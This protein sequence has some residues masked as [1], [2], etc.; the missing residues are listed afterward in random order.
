MTSPIELRNTLH[1]IDTC[2]PVPSSTSASGLHHGV[3]DNDGQQ[4]SPTARSLSSVDGPENEG[5]SGVTPTGETQPNLSPNPTRG[6][7][8]NLKDA[9]E[10]TGDDTFF[11]ESIAIEVR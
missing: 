11:V 10:E 3:R 4:K 1:P 5:D 6:R 2:P 8:T 9:R 7:I